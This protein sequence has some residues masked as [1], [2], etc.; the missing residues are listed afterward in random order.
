MAKRYPNIETATLAMGYGKLR[1][2]YDI[3]H[4][5][6]IT[7]TDY[8]IWLPIMCDPNGNWYNMYNNNDDK[9]KEL[10]IQIA[11]KDASKKDYRIKELQVDATHV[12]V[13]Y[14]YDERLKN[15]EYEYIGEYCSIFSCKDKFTS[16]HAKRGSSFVAGNIHISKDKKFSWT[17]GFASSET[18]AMKFFNELAGKTLKILQDM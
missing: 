3:R 18:E 9:K 2:T 4:A 17:S 16:I 1:N 6:G 11:I 15:Y 5:S 8:C 12:I 10:I 14:N 13:R 7:D